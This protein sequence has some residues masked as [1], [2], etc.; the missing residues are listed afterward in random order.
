MRT[1][2]YRVAAKAERICD[3][4]VFGSKAEMR[5]YAELKVAT[6][7]MAISGFTI[8]PT[9]K[10]TKHVKYRPDFMVLEKDGFHYEDVKGVWTQRFRVVV[11][12]WREFGPA[13][14]VIL[15]RSREAWKR[16]VIEGKP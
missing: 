15:T 9:V 3:G 16:K 5:R 4:I 14:L 1:N 12:L 6:Q 11:Q 10:L 13:P 8:Q 2:K 7:G